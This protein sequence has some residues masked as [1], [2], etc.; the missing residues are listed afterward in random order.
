MN[1]YAIGI[2]TGGTYT[3]G[4]LIDICTKEILSTAKVPTTHENLQYC[5]DQVM[6]SLDIG[7]GRDVSLVSLST[8]LS[9]NACIE[10]KFCRCCLILF[11]S[12]END[13]QKYGFSSGL[14][15]VSDIYFAKG[16]VSDEGKIIEAADWDE[17]RNYIDSNLS[18]FD[19]FAVVSRWG[20]KNTFLEITAKKI[21][22]EICEKPVVCGHEL[23]SELNYF[24]RAVSAYLNAQLT[25]IFASFLND[26]KMIL[27]KRQM[28]P[29]LTFVRGDGALMNEE[30]ARKKPIQTLLSGPSASVLGA[31][32]LC[33]DVKDAIIIDIGGTTSDV[34]IVEDKIVQISETGACVDTFTTSTKAINIHTVSLGGDTEVIVSNKGRISFGKQRVIPIAIAAQKYPIIKNHIKNINPTD[35]SHTSDDYIFYC[36]SKEIDQIDKNK[37]MKK[38]HFI[39]DSLLESPRSLKELRDMFGHVSILLSHLVNL[40]YVLRSSITPTDI[41]HIKGDYVAG[42]KDAAKIVV[43][44]YSGK[45]GMDTDHFCDKIYEMFVHGIYGLIVKKLMLN[46]P[47]ISAI[48]NS[49]IMPG[50]LHFTTLEKR[51]CLGIAFSSDFQLIG[52]GASSDIFVPK[53]EEI[54]KI[55]SIV[56]QNAGIG[57]AIGAVLGKISTS[58]EIKIYETEEDVYELIDKKGSIS[59]HHSFEEAIAEAERIAL[60]NVLRDFYE[61]GGKNAQTNLKKRIPSWIP[62][63]SKLKMIYTATANCDVL[64]IL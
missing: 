58:Y 2:D 43:E 37:L 41:M 10:K 4:V 47:E 22:T 28:N 59:I 57:N 32:A 34:A 55:K 23:S 38:E 35:F 27:T 56:P 54:M 6:S 40:G 50:L 53:I 19:C 44:Y 20:M 49:D 16:A 26:V 3:D 42:E 52:I 60:K 9:T 62:Y 51:A 63:Q 61:Q 15:E 1:T 12:S 21:I 17:F 48:P 18:F 36:L 13:L 14:N 8:T 7:D 31:L 11:G 46:I 45:C 25:P 29:I 33:S 39:I 5:I 24:H 64:D 30:Y